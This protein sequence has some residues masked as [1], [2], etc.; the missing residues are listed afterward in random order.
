MASTALAVT[1]ASTVAES[2]GPVWGALAASLPVSAGPAYIFLVLANDARFVAESAL[3]SCAANAATIFFLAAYVRLA[4]RG[5][6][7]AALV[8]ATALWLGLGLG[9]AYSIHTLRPTPLTALMLNATAFAL[10]LWLTR[11]TL[12]VE[13]GTAPILKAVSIS[14]FGPRSSLFSSR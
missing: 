3:G 9:L 6:G 12:L 8:T 7:S 2:A 4:A 11:K 10:G 5:N 1:V 13:T 14:L